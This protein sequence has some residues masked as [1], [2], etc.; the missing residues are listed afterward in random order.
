MRNRKVTL[1]DLRFSA[2]AYFYKLKEGGFIRREDV[3]AMLRGV[4]SS[5]ESVFLVN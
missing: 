1:D 3:E 5:K 2:N 4:T